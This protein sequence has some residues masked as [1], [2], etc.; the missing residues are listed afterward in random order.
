[1]KKMIYI[2]MIALSSTAYAHSDDDPL[3][4]MVKIDQL[5]KRD[6]KDGDPLVWNIDAWI[7]KDLNK[8]WIK[9]E[10]ERVHGEVEEAEVQLL[11]SRAIAPYWDLQTGW[12]RDI[13]PKPN[14]DWFAIGFNGVA[15]YFFEVDSSLFIGESGQVGFR[16]DAEYDIL[17]TQKLI[18][19]P[20]IEL[21]LHTK[22]DEEVGIGSG[23][24]DMDLGLRLRYEIVREFAP[25]IGVN[26]SKK[27]GRTADFVRDEGG[28]PDDVQLV[29]GIRAWF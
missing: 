18:L 10:G 17:F 6:A 23:L 5:E 26:W 2:L 11:Y 25:Y 22:N 7:G 9:T 12:R 4:T 1:M 28:D 16:L 8:F 20:E 3:L 14:R 24:S 19:S 29:V 27:F 15:P 21:N 13:K